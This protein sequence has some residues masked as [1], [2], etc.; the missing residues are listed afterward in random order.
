MTNHV[1][2]IARNISEKNL[3]IDIEEGD[4]LHW[5]SLDDEYI[6]VFQAGSPFPHFDTTNARQIFFIVPPR[7]PSRKSN[8]AVLLCPFPANSKLEYKYNVIG[9]NWSIDPKVGV[10]PRKNG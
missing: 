3:N 10:R 8:P 5:E 4:T 7:K 6:V 9:E 1:L 2:L